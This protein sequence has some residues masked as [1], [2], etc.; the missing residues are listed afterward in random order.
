MCAAVEGTLP[1][2]DTARKRY[3]HFDK[4]GE[5]MTLLWRRALEE[6]RAKRAMPNPKLKYAKRKR[7]KMTT[8][9]ATSR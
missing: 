5:R 4:V 8:I 7:K 3:A 2:I 9:G 1:A 6:I